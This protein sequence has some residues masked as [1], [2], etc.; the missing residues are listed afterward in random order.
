M[1]IESEIDNIVNNFQALK[2]SES[3]IRSISEICLTALRSDG[4]IIFCG[5][6][7]SAAD[8][9]H[10]AA[11]LVVKFNRMRKSIP[12]IAITTDTSILTAIGNDI[13]AQS[14]FER[15]IEGIGRKGD[16]LI[17]LTTSGNSENV[18]RA[19]HKA[20][21]LGIKT[22]AFTGQNGGKI[23]DIADIALQVPS[24]RTPNIQEMHI[25]CGHILCGLIE[26]NI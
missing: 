14:L 26:E 11:E 15:Q 3:V 23:K 16:V 25:A 8:S 6:G 18:L 5:N 4:K 24:N 2:S 21:E 22:I 10:L 20:K 17:G 1:D 19:F 9:Q 13:G 7:G 12:A